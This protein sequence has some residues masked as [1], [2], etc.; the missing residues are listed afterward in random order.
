MKSWD[1]S[2]TIGTG[3]SRY[4]SAVH[5]GTASTRRALRR[6]DSPPPLPPLRDDY[7]DDAR[8]IVE[9]VVDASVE[10]DDD[11]LKPV[12]PAGDEAVYTEPNDEQGIARNTAASY[13]ELIAGY[14]TEYYSN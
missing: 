4:S 3:S 1:A 14:Q 5:T 6:P 12:T 11:Y 8:T 10:E 13:I 7:Y 2:V 9:T